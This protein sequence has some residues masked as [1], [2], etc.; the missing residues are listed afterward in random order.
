MTIRHLRSGA[1]AAVAALL[2]LLPAAPAAHAVEDAGT[3]ELTLFNINDFHG[4]IT[5]EIGISLAATLQQQRAAHPNSLFLS[6]GDN[7]SASLFVSSVQ[8]D[9]PTLDYLNALGLQASA[10]GNHE[11][12][13]G[14]ADLTGRISEHADFPIL[15]A[16]V[17]DP[18]TGDPVLKPYTILQTDD[19][20][21]VA[22]IGSV[23]AET[24]QLVD[25][26]ALGGME[27]TDPV[28][29]TNR[30]AEQL[31]D[32]DLDNGEADVIVAEYH[33]RVRT[34]DP[35]DRIVTQTSPAVDVIF[36][37]H[38]HEEYVLPPGGQT[39]PG[40][41]PVLQTGNYGDNLGAVTLTLDARHEVRGARAELIANPKKIPNAQ[42]IAADPV[43]Q[44]AQRVLTDA[45]EHADRIGSRKLAD[46]AAP[47]TTGWD[48][49]QA[50][51]KGG[52]D[53]RD[54]ESTMGHLVADMYL[55]AAKGT[56]RTPA[57]LAI[58]NPGGL[59]DEFP[60]GLRSDPSTTADQI[61]VAD[62]VSVLPFANNLWTTQLTG[63]QL[64]QVLEEQWQQ[65][66]AGSMATRPY[67][68]LGLS[69]NVTYTYTGEPGA[70]GYATRGDNIDEVRIDGKPLEEGRTYTVAL[71]SFLLGG[72]DN[73]STLAQG[74]NTKDTAVVDSDAFQD[75]LR[76]L[77]V[78]T[79]RPEKQAVRVSEKPE[80]Y[81]LSGM[82]TVW[83][84]D[85]AVASPGIP[86]PER[87]SVR[88]G[89][90]DAGEVSVR[91]GAAE[92]SMPLSGL[93][94]DAGTHEV[95]LTEP[96]TGTHVVMNADF[97]GA[98]A[99]PT[100]ESSP[101]PTSEPTPAPTGAPTSAPG[102]VPTGEPVPT[103]APTAT[104]GP[105]LPAPGPS[106]SDGRAGIGGG[107]SDDLPS[108][109]ALSVEPNG[110]AADSAETGPGGLA[111]T[112]AQDPVRMVLAGL[113]VLGTGAALVLIRPRRTR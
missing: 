106:A 55:H 74:R 27:F 65:D 85:L 34:D 4:R 21:R 26:S 30:Y 10:A 48:P 24:P 51:A 50:E 49:D 43:L 110:V 69:S 79:P 66:N 1:G 87:L 75:Y 39:G 11:F 6:A 35:Q 32:G 56:G 71:P 113:L 100:P 96:T 104:A 111:R 95:E 46:L 77:G 14:L 68:Q 41:R 97:T 62:A 42:T 76:E 63:A 61:T 83:V 45:K 70:A 15:G 40:Q 17:V 37:G 57:D 60:A 108:G 5:P 54:R 47:V 28:A 29:A 86:T 107:G 2:V 109:G 18:A 64:R 84:S 103:A 58:V 81:D 7:V 102:P 94:L 22:V 33:E 80:A 101:A 78:V 25:P 93:G 3:T 112:G 13:K 89:G 52:F 31:S 23:T 36:T 99:E 44:Q 72:G 92:V 88:I 90:R 9:E 59:R 53:Q 91:D 8:D 12:D 19:G 98:G 20:V 67:L 16:N 82:Y 38:T 105:D 73:F